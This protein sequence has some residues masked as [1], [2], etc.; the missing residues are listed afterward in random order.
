MNV[1]IS[2]SWAYSDHYE[3]LAEWIFEEDWYVD[4]E[5]IRFRNTSVPKDDPI[6]FAPTDAKLQSAIYE[7]ILVSNVVV[8]PTGMYANYSKWIGKEIAG[9]KL[10]SKPI[11]AVN[12]W[13]QKRSSSIV[14]QSATDLVA[15]NKQSII[16]SIWNTGK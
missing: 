6:H 14:V 1:F 11:V 8:I 9:A 10:Y 5:L 15:W 3:R 13:S 7:R 16:N 12:P 2:H 4:E